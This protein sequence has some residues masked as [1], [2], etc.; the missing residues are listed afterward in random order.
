[1]RLSAFLIEWLCWKWLKNLLSLKNISVI[2]IRKNYNGKNFLH[3]FSVNKKKLTNKKFVTKKFHKKI[4]LNKKFLKKKI[5]ATQK[6]VEKNL[7]KKRIRKIMYLS[8]KKFKGKKK[9]L[10]KNFHE[11]IFQLTKKI[12]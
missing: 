5:T 11:K 4:S 6:C 9:I 3:N 8:K 12:K 2:K 1:M 10:C 7:K